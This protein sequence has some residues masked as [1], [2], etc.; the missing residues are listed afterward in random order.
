MSF[1]ATLCT[2]VE[3]LLNHGL[4]QSA[5]AQDAAAALEGRCLD[6]IAE[7]AP[8]R[9]RLAVESGRLRVTLSE[10]GDADVTLRGGPLT[11]MRLAGPDGEH[12]IRDGTLRLI[13]DAELAGHFHRLLRLCRPDL[14]DELARLLGDPLAHGLAE[15]ARAFGGFGRQAAD[16]LGRSV[17]GY[18][19]EE[20]RSLPTRVE[21]EA[22]CADVDRL[23]DDVARA[24]ARL[25]RLGAMER[26]L[27]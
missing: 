26:A 19:T 17:A 4:A 15:M 8:A 11:L 7:G 10:G 1:A 18:F 27:D 6:I 5:S 2:P 3:Q 14:E 21:V 16:A 23:V 12:L 9:L 24:E 20:Q 25:L 22:F 13:G